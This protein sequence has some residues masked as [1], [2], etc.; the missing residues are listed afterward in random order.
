MD[1]ELLRILDGDDPE[2]KP[3]PGKRERDTIGLVD[4][5]SGE[6]E[7][8]AKD[9]IVP[10]RYVLKPM[11]QLFGKGTGADSIDPRDE[12]YLPLL[13]PIEQEILE[14]WVENP[15]LS[16]GQVSLVLEQLGMNPEGPAINDPLKERIQLRLRIALSV[17]DFSRKD[18]KLAI[19]KIGKSVQFHTREAGPRGYLNF[20]R[21]YLPR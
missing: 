14:Y 21:Q 8:A 10:R 3:A 5:S 13:L 18:V 15:S 6:I 16:D 19:R 12:K 9:G 4:P 2:G 17:H 11:S 20:I 1:D 7:I